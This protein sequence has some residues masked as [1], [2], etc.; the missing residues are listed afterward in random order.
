MR[1]CVLLTAIVACFVACGSRTDPYAPGEPDSEET[2]VETD[3]DASDAAAMPVDATGIPNESD[4]RPSEQADASGRPTDGAAVDAQRDGTAFDDAF[5]AVT[6]E[7]APPDVAAMDVESVD[8]ADGAPVDATADAIDD[9]LPPIDVQAP[10]N[11]PS[12][13]GG[14]AR[15]F[16]VSESADLLSFDPVSSSFQLIGAIACPNTASFPNSMAVSRSGIAYIAFWDGS[17]YRVRTATASCQSTPFV[18]NQNG[19]LQFGMGFA[20]DDSGKGETLYVGSQED[21]ARLG[22]IDTTTFALNVI[23]TLAP[24][25]STPE[26]TGTGAGQLFGFETI[27]ANDSA[28]V[29]I[30]KATAT[31]VAESMLTGLERGNA[32]AF[33]YWGE[34]FYTFTWPTGSPGSVA[35]R[36]RPADGSIVQVASTSEVIVGAGVSTCAP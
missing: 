5:D 30:D 22:W 28:I 6:A 14:V 36:F 9:V 21:P 13:R 35:T 7:V 27:D 32:W 4:G 25:V 34:D 10:G 20:R 31:V 15:I 33:A 12:C 16:V 23:G 2:V 19:F 17:L 18:A 11:D 8:A 24:T 29:Q 3:S 1:A 26:L